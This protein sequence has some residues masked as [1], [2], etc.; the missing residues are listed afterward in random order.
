MTKPTKVKAIG[1]GYNISANNYPSVYLSGS[2]VEFVGSESGGVD[3]VGSFQDN[4]LPNCLFQFEFNNPW[5][6][7]PWAAIGTAVDDN[8][9]GNDRTNFDVN[10]VKVFHLKFY[11]GGDDGEYNDFYVKVTREEDTDTKN[12]TMEIGYWPS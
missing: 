12:F 9:W 3:V 10:D 11:D 7:D 1:D 5:I 8:G 6:G 2:P 4:N